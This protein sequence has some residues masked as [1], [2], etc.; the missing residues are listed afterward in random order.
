MNDGPFAAYRAMR[1]AGHVNFDPA[2]EHAARRLEALHGAL[3]GYRPA[4]APRRGVLG[5]LGL[6]RLIFG[7]GPARTPKGL[8]I[9]GPVGRGKSMLMDLFFEQA[10]VANKRRVHFHEF[11]LEIHARLHD[12]R[13][14][15][16]S[17]PRDE[18]IIAPVARAIAADA[19]LLCFDEFQVTDIA[20][21]MVIGRLFEALFGHGVIVVATSNTPPD[22]L[23]EGGLQRELFLPFIDRIGAHM[24]LHE[25]DGGA[26]HRLALMNGMAVY[27][28]PAD[29]EAEERLAS[30]FARLTGRAATQSASLSVQ[31]REITVPRCTAGVAW[32]KF[33]ELCETPM[34]AADYLEIARNYHTV[35]LSGIPGLGPEMRNEARRFITLVDAL[36]EHKVNL[37]CTAEQAADALYPDGDHADEFKR[38]ASRLVE[39]GSREYFSAPHVA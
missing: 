25:L 9:C 34:G 16:R 32:F 31:G 18:N 24:N 10:P 27:H 23:Y 15:A 38:T 20:D 14:A 17:K 6:D 26:D 37:I 5:L 28:S 29:T 3:R 7:G 4:I 13:L 2:Q 21:A 33:A 12:K 19:W 8:Y 36:Y 1:D 35:I 30:T 11:M 39:M 22:R